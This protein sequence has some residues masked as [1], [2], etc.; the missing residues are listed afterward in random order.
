MAKVTTAVTLDARVLRAV[1]ARAARAGTGESEVIEE[2]L[3][4]V[5]GLDAPERWWASAGL[6]EEDAM[7]LADE[8]KH[9]TRP[10]AC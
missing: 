10:W 6:S 8:A 3:C 7:K 9:R 2:A 4:R 5:L 1:K